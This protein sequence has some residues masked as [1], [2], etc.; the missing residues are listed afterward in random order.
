LLKDCQKERGV[1]LY[2]DLHGHSQNKNTFLYGCDPLQS[3]IR[4]VTEGVNNLTRAE[5]TNYSIFPRIFPKVLVSVSNLF[6]TMKAKEPSN[7]SGGH[8][9]STMRQNSSVSKPRQ[10][11]SGQFSFKDCSLKVQRSKARVL[12]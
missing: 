8:S 5:L 12:G 3:N 2:I 4:R 10:N 11:Q 7:K 6:S 9:G 1:Y